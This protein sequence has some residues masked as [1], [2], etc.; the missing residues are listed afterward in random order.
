MSTSQISRLSF[1]IALIFFLTACKPAPGV[2]LPTPTETSIPRPFFTETPLPP[3][4]YVVSYGDTCE[5]IAENFKVSIEDIIKRNGMSSRCTIFVGSTLVIPRSTISQEITSPTPFFPQDSIIRTWATQNALATPIRTP[6]IRAE[7][8]KL[9]NAYTE[10]GNLYFRT[11]TGQ[12][13]QL[14]NSGKDR[15]PILSDDGQ[16]IAFY[17]G[18]DAGNFHV[19]D[20]NGG[21]DKTII[22]S[23]MP[24]LIGHGI[25]VFP[26]FV[27]G[28]HTLLFNTYLC[29]GDQHLY[30]APD[31]SI[32]L[33]NLNTDTKT[34]ESIVENLSGAYGRS[35]E[36]S[37]NGKYVS[38]AGS[39]HI[40]IYAV[41][42]EHFK[43]AHPNVLS[44]YITP[45]DEYLPK[46][47]W[48]PDSSELIIV[49]AADNE[50]S[51]PSTPPALYDAFRYTLKDGNAMKISLDKFI[52]WD[53]QYDNWCISP[54]RNWILFAGNDTGDRRDGSLYYLGDLVNGQTRVYTYDP[55]PL[56]Y[57]CKWSPD[58]K[59]FSF[60]NM[61]GLI[62]SVD[63][64]LPVPVGGSF[65]EWVDATHYYY[66]VDSTEGS[67]IYLGEIKGN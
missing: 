33:Y 43:I 52:L 61:L 60:T 16:K 54:D 67:R 51:D 35:F 58:S 4:I 10:N 55:G 12:I 22:V 38:V 66:L 32:D 24:L 31:C 63:G 2:S 5:S 27:P 53:K 7:N 41:S 30:D 29:E 46:Q 34:I 39:G 13:L 42:S 37:P 65:L 49:R 64:G 25:I 18:E 62:G 11:N 26:T 45:P 40:D 19:I 9:P 44:Y 20:S 17:R 14:T 21:Q 3:F 6:V 59:H 15:D 57:F 47:Y 56:L 50:S 36:I 8:E 23:E 48:S 1:W 28:T